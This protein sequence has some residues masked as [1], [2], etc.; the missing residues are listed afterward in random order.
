LLRLLGNGAPDRLSCQVEHHEA[1]IGFDTCW[2]K[3]QYIRD[4]KCGS[5][6]DA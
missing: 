1:S 5:R 6:A 2:R 3:G 4:C